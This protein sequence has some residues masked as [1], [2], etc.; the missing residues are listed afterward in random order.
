MA[1]PISACR[2]SG[3]AAEGGFQRAHRSGG[4]TFNSAA[5]AGVRQS[6]RS[7]HGIVEQQRNAI[8]VTHDQ[9]RIRQIR[10]DGVRLIQ[11]GR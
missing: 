10:D 5:P 6:D 9:R 4:H 3:T 1:G 8:R 2:S 11:I 7:F